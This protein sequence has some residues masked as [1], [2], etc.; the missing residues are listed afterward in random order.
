MNRGERGQALAETALAFPLQVLLTLGILQVGLLS[1]GR[2]GARYAAFA[3]AR[4]ALTEPFPSGPGYAAGR[5]RRSDPVRAAQIAMIPMA[6]SAL[7]GGA[8]SR[9]PAVARLTD[10]G[11]L[12]SA[13]ARTR[14]RIRRGKAGVFARVE[15][16][17][18]LVVPGAGRLIAFLWAL[19]GG[20]GES[21]VGSAP[22]VP[23]A[24]ECEL[25]R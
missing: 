6:G 3:A 22:R 17:F 2:A 25:P 10:P 13:A 8:F 7:S 1:V 5:P 23:L 9:M 14:V 18:G 4:A 11:R 16:D 24:A 19:R 20:G 12:A 21:P 15:Y